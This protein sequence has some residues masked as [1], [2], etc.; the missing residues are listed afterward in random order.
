MNSLIPVLLLLVSGCALLPSSFDNME[1]ARLVTIN[2][3]SQ[4]RGVCKD[5][6]RASVAAA[7][8]TAQAQWLQRYGASLPR[9]SRMHAMEQDLVVMSQSLSDSYAKGPVSTVYCELKLANI[10]KATEAVIDISAQRPR[11]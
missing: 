6:V 8:I 10:N 7:Q 1:H 11:F 9:N 4:D 3:L 5:P 2:Q